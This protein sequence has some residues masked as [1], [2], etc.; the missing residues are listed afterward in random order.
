VVAAAPSASAAGVGNVWLIINNSHCDGA[1]TIFY[2]GGAVEPATAAGGTSW[3][4]GDSGDNIIY[5]RVQLGSTQVFDGYALCTRGPM[6]EIGNW[7]FTPTRT[8]QDY[9]W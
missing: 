8:G 2:V 7:Y 1:G 4:G 6:I 5:P 9:W 3:S